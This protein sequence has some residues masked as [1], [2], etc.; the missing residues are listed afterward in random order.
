M[1]W[2]KTS[3]WRWTAQLLKFI[4]DGKYVLAG[5][6]KQAFTSEEF[7]HFLEELTK[8]YPFVSIQ[9]G[10]NE[11]YWTVSHTRRKVGDKIQLVGDDLFV[12][13][14]PRFL[15][16]GI[17]KGSLTPSHQNYQIGSDRNSGCN[18]DGEKY[19]ATLSYLSPFWRN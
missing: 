12:T 17:E 1:N 4:K 6:G 15:K 10:C 16:E 11:I 5:E 3:L 2:A 19:V 14:T 18:Q 7:T 8:Q 13:G 9:D